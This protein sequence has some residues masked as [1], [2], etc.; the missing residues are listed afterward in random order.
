MNNTFWEFSIS[1]LAATFEGMHTGGHGFGS[2]CLHTKV[3]LFETNETIGGALR[4]TPG[5]KLVSRD[6]TRHF[7]EY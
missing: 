2:F 4:D 1:K 6:E 3:S 5:N 7:I